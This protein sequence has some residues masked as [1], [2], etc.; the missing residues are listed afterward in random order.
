MSAEATTIIKQQGNRPTEL[1]SAEKLRDSVRSA[2]LSISLPEGHAHDTA[3]YIC[4]HVETWLDDKPEVTSDDIRRLTAS[5]LE[6][7]SPEAG[8]LYKHHHTIL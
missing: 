2:C 4:K 6:T 3:V 1:F 8:Y 7:I 5:Y